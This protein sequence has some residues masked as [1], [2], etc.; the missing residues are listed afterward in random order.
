MMTCY[1]KNKKDPKFHR[2]RELFLEQCYMSNI[3]EEDVKEYD[4]LL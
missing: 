1:P 4:G 2:L 3:T